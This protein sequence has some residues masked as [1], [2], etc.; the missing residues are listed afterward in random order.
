MKTQACANMVAI[1]SYFYLI[2]VIMKK[3]LMIL[4]LIVTGVL[5]TGQQSFAMNV[6]VTQRYIKKYLQMAQDINKFKPIQEV[7]EP[8]SSS[9]PNP[10][11]ASSLASSS[12]SDNEEKSPSTNTRLSPTVDVFLKSKGLTS[13]Y[14]DQSEHTKN[15]IRTCIID[16]Q[17]ILPDESILNTV[18]R[19]HKITT[20]FIFHNERFEAIIET[21]LKSFKVL[22]NNTCNA[23]DVVK[24]LSY[25]HRVLE[26][27]SL[28]V[29]INELNQVASL[30]RKLRID[31]AWETYLAKTIP[32]RLDY[33]ARYF[34]HDCSVIL[35][36][37]AGKDNF[38]NNIKKQRQTIINNL[39]YQL[40]APEEVL[41]FL[42]K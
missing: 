39:L 34:T 41:A 27:I 8:S 26:S 13:F 14:K 19:T 32:N 38:L 1:K 35:D 6:D 40:L 18:C 37:L 33:Q 9:S 31:Y 12:C 24:I 20:E 23:Q 15:F 29:K 11:P 17:H 30:D 25:A 5:L 2:G 28:V 4:T 42:D 7:D 36:Q 10:S 21:L 3:T 22:H 16:L